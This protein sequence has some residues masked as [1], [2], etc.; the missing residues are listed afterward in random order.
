MKKMGFPAT[1]I[2]FCG[3]KLLRL[4][5]GNRFWFWID[6][7]KRGNVFDDVKK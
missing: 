1:K 3:F 7:F 2:E 5:E 4:K 6:E